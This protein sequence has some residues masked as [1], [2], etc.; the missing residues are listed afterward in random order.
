MPTKKTGAAPHNPQF[1]KREAIDFGFETAKKN[2]LFFVS[3]FIVSLLIFI[4]SQVAKGVFALDNSALPSVIYS[5]IFWIVN[6][7]ISMGYIKISVL[8]T[9]GKKP[10]LANLFHTQSLLKYIVVSIIRSVV[11]FVGFLLLVVPGVILALRLQFATYLVVD[12]DMGIIDSIT[13]SWEGTK[14]HTWNLFW[15]FL[16]LIGI[17]IVGFLALIVGLLITVPLSMIATAYVYRRLFS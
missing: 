4:V 16:L 1:N 11:I 3:V 15:F 2:F 17:N 5:L 10:K 12:R 13:K 9:D 6:S 8:F 7:I 14:G